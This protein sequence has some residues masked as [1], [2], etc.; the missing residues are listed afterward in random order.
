MHKRESGNWKSLTRD[1]VATASG[2]TLIVVAMLAL[3]PVAF[4]H[5]EKDRHEFDIDNASLIEA[6][7]ELAGTADVQLLYSHEHV[8]GIENRKLRG[9][10]HVQEA[11][12]ILL[13]GTNVGFKQ[14][15]D[16]T[17]ALYKPYPKPG[18]GHSNQPAALTESGEVGEQS[19]LELFA[20]TLDPSPLAATPVRAPRKIDEIIVT[21]TR[22]TESLQRVP[23]SLYVL[24]SNQLQRK[25]VQEFQE[26]VRDIPGLSVATVNRG[27]LSIGIRGIRTLTPGS[28]AGTISYYLDEV[29]LGGESSL[30][31][32]ATFDLERIEVL[33]GR[34]ARCSARARWPA[35]SASSPTSP[36]RMLTR[37]LWRPACS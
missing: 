32:L 1:G 28:G 11:L 27:S 17:Y 35:P 13:D 19:R 14:V 3:A 15:A 8:A 5:T 12:S 34:R 30:P 31:Q 4:A 36:T 23:I 16:R 22:R 7:H 9:E 20:G 18:P 21:A 37:R 24:S 25:N 10:F 2:L 6:L 29:G 33:R 26:V